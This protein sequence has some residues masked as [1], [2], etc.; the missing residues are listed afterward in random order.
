MMNLFLLIMHDV[1]VGRIRIEIRITTQPCQ[2]GYHKTNDTESR[3][4]ARTNPDA[5]QSERTTKK[6]CKMYELIQKLGGVNKHQTQR[7]C[8]MYELIQK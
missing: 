7:E 3:R 8:E 5:R 4:V 6:E 1:H 2:I